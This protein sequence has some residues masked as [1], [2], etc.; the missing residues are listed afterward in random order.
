VN[1]QQHCQVLL[2]IAGGGSGGGARGSRRRLG[3]GGGG[4]GGTG[5]GGSGLG[6]KIINLGGVVGEM[7]EVRKHLLNG[8]LACRR[9]SKKPE[10]HTQVEKRAEQRKGSTSKLS[11]CKTHLTHHTKP[12]TDAG[13]T[14]CCSLLRERTLTAPT[15]SSRSP[16]T[17]MKLHCASCAL[18]T[19]GAR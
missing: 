1:T 17:K 4:G 19:C 18:R 16:T 9:V 10:K 6:G 11:A 5:S 3:G 7:L 12:R 13:N 2:G 8:A 14:P 15:C